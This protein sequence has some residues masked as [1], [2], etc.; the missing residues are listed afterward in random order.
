MTASAK[1]PPVE[2]MFANQAKRFYLVLM[3][4]MFFAGIVGI[5]KRL[6]AAMRSVSSRRIRKP[7]QLT[8]RTWLL[9]AMVFASRL[10]QVKP[11]R[12]TALLRKAFAVIVSVNLMKRLKIVPEIAAIA[13]TEFA[14]TLKHSNAVPMIARCP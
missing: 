8:A 7:A 10:K 2:M 13:E 5:W 4:V 1:T 9:V 12:R 14:M 11:V 6:F 3:T